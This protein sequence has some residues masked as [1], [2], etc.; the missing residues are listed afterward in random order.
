M[1]VSEC[2]LVLD[3]VPYLGDSRGKLSPPWG[4]GCEHVTVLRGCVCEFVLFSF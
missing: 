2:L 3:S 1:R 4:T